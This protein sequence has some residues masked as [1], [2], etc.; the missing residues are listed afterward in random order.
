M[1]GKAREAGQHWQRPKRFEPGHRFQTRYHRREQGK[2]SKYG[3]TF[4]LAVALLPSG[5]SE[6]VEHV[7]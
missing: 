5:G 2:T 1:I 6:P 7:R 4:S 3:R